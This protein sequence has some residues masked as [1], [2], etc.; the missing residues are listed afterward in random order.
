[1]TESKLQSSRRA[2]TLLSITDTIKHKSESSTWVKELGYGLERQ[3][4]EYQF[5]A[6]AENFLF[7]TAYRED[8]GP[9]QPS[10]QWVVLVK[11]QGVAPIHSFP[12]SAKG[13]DRQKSFSPQNITSGMMLN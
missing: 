13:K 8:V 2:E 9:T 4:T 10:I 5:P 7:A 1:M 11:V 3:R 12:S 6:D